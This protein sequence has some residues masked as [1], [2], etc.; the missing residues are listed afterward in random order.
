MRVLRAKEFHQ[1]YKNLIF[2]VENQG[3]N[4]KTRT[5]RLQLTNMNSEKRRKELQNCLQ[6][7]FLSFIQ[8]HRLPHPLII[9]RKAK[10]HPSPMSYPI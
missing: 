3:F 4:E 6:G 5:S 7:Q 8:S 9:F 2:Y 10:S 1:I